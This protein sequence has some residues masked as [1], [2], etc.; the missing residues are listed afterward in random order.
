VRGIHDAKKRLVQGAELRA[1]T[2]NAAVDSA[3]AW[4]RMAGRDVTSVEKDN[5]DGTSMYMAADF[6]LSRWRLRAR[7]RLAQLSS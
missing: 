6:P 4:Y 7:R 2:E 3:V 1:K 5:V